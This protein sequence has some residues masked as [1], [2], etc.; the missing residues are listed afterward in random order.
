MVTPENF[1]DFT[2]YLAALAIELDRYANV[3]DDVIEDIVRREGSCMWLYSAGEEPEW[4]GDDLT[5]RELAASICAGCTAKLACL[6]LALRTAGPFT[7]GVWGA[8]SEEDRRALYPIW[9]DRRANK[10]GGDPR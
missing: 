2:G 4:S 7:L 8:L 5:D 9:R 6:E 1:D 3:P 10:D